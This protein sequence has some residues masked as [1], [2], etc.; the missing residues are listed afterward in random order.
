M[1][2]ISSTS[3]NSHNDF[4][5]LHHN[6]YWDK[7]AKSINTHQLDDSVDE[8]V[9]SALKC[10]L[11][12]H[13]DTNDHAVDLMQRVVSSGPNNSGPNL[14]ILSPTF[15]IDIWLTNIPILKS[16]SHST[17][18]DDRINGDETSDM[19]EILLSVSMETSSS[20]T[21]NNIITKGDIVY[22]TSLVLFIWNR[23]QSSVT[24]G[25]QTVTDS[26]PLMQEP[27]HGVGYTI[28]KIEINKSIL[29]SL[30]TIEEIKSFTDVLT[31]GMVELLY[32]NSNNNN[33]L[34]MTGRLISDATE[35]F[36]IAMMSCSVRVVEPIYACELQ[37]DTSQLGNLYAVLTKRRGHVHKEDIIEGTSLFLMSAMLPVAESFGFAQ[38]L[39]K[40]TS[41]NGTAP[42]LSFSHY[43][44]IDIDPFW[45][46]TTSEELEDHGDMNNSKEMNLARL[47]I[48]NVR[49]RKGLMV[50]EKI[51]V[52]AEKQRTLNK[53]K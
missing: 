21:H 23:L 5:T 7:L 22:N 27:L 25:F 14:L 51:V 31:N 19:E 16:E 26:G 29:N 12:I 6:T 2:K 32:D 33:N 50:E 36:R 43:Q 35:A 40:R 11:Q 24:A 17:I 47:Y 9:D 38:E 20:S 3:V 48:D 39:L 41:G 10:P 15:Q 8:M 30:L 28:E 53:K 34:L 42:Q 46:P 4:N 18:T 44:I 52:S 37:C 45:K 49:K 13:D 1:H